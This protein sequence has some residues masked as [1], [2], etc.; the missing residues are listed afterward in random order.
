MLT[1]YSDNVTSSSK[2][3]CIVDTKEKLRGLLLPM[4]VTFIDL[5]KIDYRKSQ[6]NAL[7][8]NGTLKK[9]SASSFP[10]SSSSIHVCVFLSSLSGS[11]AR[12]RSCDM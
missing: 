6:V 9:L 12:A 1:M 10:R 4:P 7:F 11:V 3:C 5:C 8:L 2:Q